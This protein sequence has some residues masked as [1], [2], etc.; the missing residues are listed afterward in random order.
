MRLLFLS[1][2][3]ARIIPHRSRSPLARDF[4]HPH[5]LLSSRSPSVRSKRF[6]NPQRSPRSLRPDRRI[7][8]EHSSDGCCMFDLRETS[9][10]LSVRSGGGGGREGRQQYDPLG[11]EAAGSRGDLW[12][13]VK[14]LFAGGRQQA[15]DGHIC[16]KET[17][18]HA[19]RRQ[20]QFDA[21]ILKGIVFS[22]FKVLFASVCLAHFKAARD[23][24]N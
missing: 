13:P 23:A 1:S 10:S 19:Q 7:D 4:L 16:M 21:L 6:N 12:L 22:V 15:V 8:H 5:D 24:T 17:V 14:S 2:N 18:C 11:G 20:S 3:Y 9:A